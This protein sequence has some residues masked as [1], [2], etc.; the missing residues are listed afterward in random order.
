MD[1]AQA[2]VIEQGNQL[3]VMHGDDSKLYV[4]FKM[5]AVHQGALSEQ[6]GRPIYKDIPFIEINFP[7]DRTKKIYRPVKMENDLQSPADP[8]RFPRQWEA[9]QNQRE[10]V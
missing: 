1:F 5:E 3:H 9:F 2:R 4:E 8:V 6:E 10:Q 7:G